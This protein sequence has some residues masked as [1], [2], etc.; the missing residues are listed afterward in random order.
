[1][2]V[3]CHDRSECNVEEQIWWVAKKKQQIEI[4]P[5][6]VRNRISRFFA[7]IG[8][9]ESAPSSCIGSWK[10]SPDAWPP[11]GRRS[12]L[13]HRHRRRGAQGGGGRVDW[14]GD[15]LKDYA[16]PRQDIQRPKRLYKAWKDDTKPQKGYTKIHN[17]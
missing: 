10:L 17:I 15:T 3:E 16:K 9:Q 8:R 12:A 4:G 14:G 1:M 7:D 2:G 5:K 11:R 6:L 13:G